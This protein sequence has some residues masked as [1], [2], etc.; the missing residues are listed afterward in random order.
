MHRA[1]KIVAATARTFFAFIFMWSR[2]GKSC[3]LYFELYIDHSPSLSLIFIEC[4]YNQASLIYD[5]YRI[6]D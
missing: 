3:S 2:P 1:N 5:E 4:I 6:K